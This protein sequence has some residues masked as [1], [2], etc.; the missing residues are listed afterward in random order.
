MSALA[1]IDI[2]LWCAQTNSA[3][4]QVLHVLRYARHVGEQ[5]GIIL[6]ALYLINH[7]RVPRRNAIEGGVRGVDKMI[8]TKNGFDKLDGHTEIL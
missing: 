4:E 6:D 1:L 8:R 3:L 2:A 7:S 5:I